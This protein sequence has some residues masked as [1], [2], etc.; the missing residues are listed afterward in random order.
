MT[1]TPPPSGN[2]GKKEPGGHIL[3]P[4]LTPEERQ[5]LFW[6]GLDLFNGDQFFAAHESWEA[7][8]RSTTPQPKDLFQGLIQLAAGMHHWAVRHRPTVAARVL[9]KGRARLEPFRPY[10]HGLDLELLIEAVL[11]WED[12]LVEP[13]GEPPPA[14]RI[15]VV[16]SDAVR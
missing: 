7:I 9:A 3:H 15:E 8:W 1:T 14:P 2:G 6:E 10:S 11:E 12:W 4:T 5:R 16:N 13:V